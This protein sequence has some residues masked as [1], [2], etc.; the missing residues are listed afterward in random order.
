MMIIF[1][2]IDPVEL[3][4]SKSRL[5]RI[6]SFQATCPVSFL[7]PRSREKLLEIATRWSLDYA[8]V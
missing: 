3:Q 2:A 1:I 6:F 7:T 4:P 5:S 8:S